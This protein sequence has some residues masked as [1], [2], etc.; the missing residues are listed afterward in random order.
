VQDEVLQRVLVAAHACPTQ[1]ERHSSRHP[2][3]RRCLLL[4]RSSS[5]P[6]A[7]SSITWPS[8]TRSSAWSCDD[9][10]SATRTRRSSRRGHARIIDGNYALLRKFGGRA[11]LAT[12]LGVVIGNLFADYRNSIWGRWRPS[13]AAV[14][15]GP[16]GIRIEEMLYREGH[17]L[18]ET[19]E[20][21]HSTGV[22]LSDSEIARLAAKIPPRER[23]NE[24]TLEKADTAGVIELHP[25]ADAL[26]AAP[27]ASQ[28]LRVLLAIGTLSD[29]NA[30][31]ADEQVRSVR[32]VFDAYVA[33]GEVEIDR[34][35]AP[36]PQELDTKLQTGG[37][38]VVH[39]FGHGGL[40]AARDEGFLQLDRKG[41]RPFPFYANDFATLVAGS[42]VRLEFLNACDT[43]RAGTDTDPARSSLAAALLDRGVP[44]VI[45]TQYEMPEKGSHLL[46]WLI[47]NS[48]AAGRTLGDAVQA[49]RRAMTYADAREFFDWGIPV[50]YTSDPTIVV[51]KPL[52]STRTRQL[53]KDYTE[54][55]SSDR[56]VEKLGGVTRPGA[57]SLVSSA[58]ARTPRR[59]R[60]RVRVAL[61]DI[62]AKAGF[63]PALAA[64]ANSA[65]GYFYF[66]VVHLPVPSGAVV[67]D[68]AS[69]MPRAAADDAPP[70]L[71]LPFLDT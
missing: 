31:N 43:G 7:L 48:L 46:A 22:M 11:K 18:R 36:T 6:N 15:L 21:L 51:F 52:A 69:I 63:L 24:V 17:S 9:I 59:A 39:Y 44:A 20:E 38:D 14:R 57:A 61:A 16:I 37:Y 35:H 32:D 3:R 60:A 70:Q 42:G 13:A 29:D 28:R 50:L 34:V 40:D 58:T 10:R 67:K 68:L 53:A 65:Q 54:V 26:R 27:P 30:V 62:D 1:N 12:Y 2:R 33:A 23:S 19:T 55:F 56:A 71:Y 41:G 64:A 4:R 45:A 47:Y 66:D 8:S 49:G 5:I 25:N